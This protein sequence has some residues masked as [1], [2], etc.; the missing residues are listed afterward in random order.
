MLGALL[1]AYYPFL[2]VPFMPTQS[3][4]HLQ[5]WKKAP[6]SPKKAHSKVSRYIEEFPCGKSV[7]SCTV[8][9]LEIY[10]IYLKDAND[11]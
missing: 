8:L 5:S 4:T 6:F 10:N 7:Q 11:S 3:N 1:S 9:C 2:I